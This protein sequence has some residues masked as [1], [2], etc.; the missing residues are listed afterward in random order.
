MIKEY[1]YNLVEN[2]LE[3]INIICN[4]N[5]IPNDKNSPFVTSGIRLG[6]P[7]MTTR[8]FTKSNFESLG[9]ILSKALKEIST[10][11][12]IENV[13]LYSFDVDKLLQT[14]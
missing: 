9:L 8:G 5:T 3:R 7:L 14:I 12:R 10:K 11:D 13:Y 2:E 1:P 4:K 6:T